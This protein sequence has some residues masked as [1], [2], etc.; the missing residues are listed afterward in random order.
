MHA[1]HVLFRSL[2]FLF[3]LGV[4]AAL[5]HSANK[6]SESTSVLLIR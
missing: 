2:R 3:S 5:E 4:L 6:L 1:L